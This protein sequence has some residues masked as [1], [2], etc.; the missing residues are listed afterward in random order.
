MELWQQRCLDPASNVPARSVRVQ[1]EVMVYPGW[2]YDGVCCAQK[3]NLRSLEALQS[4]RPTAASVTFELLMH[5]KA[6]E[7]ACGG[8]LIKLAYLIG[9]SCIFQ[10]NH[11]AAAPILSNHAMLARE[12]RIEGLIPGVVSG[13]S[14]SMPD[15]GTGVIQQTDIEHLH[16]TTSAAQVTVTVPCVRRSHPALC[17]RTHPASGRSSYA[18]AQ[19]QSNPTRV[20]RLVGDVPACSRGN[21][22]VR[23]QLF[24]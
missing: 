8:S 4:W 11:N 15:A 12:V 22:A 21:T 9:T 16:A 18:L 24:H 20:M 13:P 3:T 5:R 2:S 10:R 7:V 19:T 14:T 23:S 17:R 1:Q 6:Y